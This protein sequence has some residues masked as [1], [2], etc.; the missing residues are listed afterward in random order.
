MQVS[1]ISYSSRLQ[2]GSG[3]YSIDVRIQHPSFLAIQSPIR[4]NH[5][6]N[7]S[8]DQCMTMPPLTPMVFPR[9]HTRLIIGYMNHIVAIITCYEICLWCAQVRDR[10][11]NNLRSRNMSIWR[12][13]QTLKLEIGRELEYDRLNR[14]GSCRDKSYLFPIIFSFAQQIRDIRS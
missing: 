3:I 12:I 7:I 5:T 2:V 6:S 4:E 9:T 10:T 1:P 14:R 13:A 11:R 8:A